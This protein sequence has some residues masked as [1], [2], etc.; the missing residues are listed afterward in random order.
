MTL[1][2]LR[3]LLPPVFHLFGYPRRL[4]KTRGKYPHFPSLLYSAFARHHRQNAF[5]RKSNA[6][7]R[8]LGKDYVRFL[9]NWLTLY[10]LHIHRLSILS[11]TN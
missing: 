2:C 8:G 11:K 7:H 9:S 6:G 10:H 4:C 1:Y 3:I 5:Q